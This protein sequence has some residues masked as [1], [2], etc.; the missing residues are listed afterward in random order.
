[1]PMSLPYE[2]V[3]LVP[4]SDLQNKLFDVKYPRFWPGA[5]GVA[6]P[7]R[8]ATVPRSHPS[9]Q[10]WTA[11]PLPVYWVAEDG[12]VASGV[13]QRTGL[14]ALRSAD[15]RTDPPLEM[16]PRLDDGQEPPVGTRGER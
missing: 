2:L 11:L 3:A 16:Y 14:E 15:P 8:P 12:S 6:L 5:L 13:P 7:T 4:Q 9:S 10:S 1:M